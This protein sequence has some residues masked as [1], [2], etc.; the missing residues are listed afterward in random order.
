MNILVF[1]YRT[2][3][4]VAIASEPA[5]VAR[6]RLK[7]LRKQGMKLALRA[8]LSSNTFFPRMQ[9]L[10]VKKSNDGIITNHRKDRQWFT[11]IRSFQMNKKMAVIHGKALFY[12]RFVHW[13]DAHKSS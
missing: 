13:H 3:L 8:E 7:P 10:S 1:Q 6:R 2:V 9:L 11:A 4:R 5:Q 12:S